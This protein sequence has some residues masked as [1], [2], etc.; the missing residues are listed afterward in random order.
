MDSLRK[1]WGTAKRLVQEGK[2]NEAIFLLE[3]LAA[4]G[5]VYVFREIGNLY[6]KGDD[7]LEQ[8]FDKALSWL[9]RGYFEHNCADCASVLGFMYYK[10]EGV[11]QNFEKALKY[12]EDVSENDCP[13]AHL[14]AGIINHQGLA[15]EVNIDRA[16][17]LYE[18]SANTGNVWALRNLAILRRQNG[19]FLSGLVMQMRCAA[20]AFSIMRNDENDRRLR[21][22]F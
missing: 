9:R 11:E 6:R 8:N 7:G 10:G 4:E 16:R 12:F 14:L 19:Q 21:G 18:K 1:M 22:G 17:E 2:A 5:E 3:R 15:G 20:K 13:E